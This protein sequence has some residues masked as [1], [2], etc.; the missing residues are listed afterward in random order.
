MSDVSSTPKADI[1]SVETD[2]RYVPEADI[3]I[4]MIA[5]MGKGLAFG[6]WPTVVATY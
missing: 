3:R 2:V 4:S 1:R 6:S 5:T